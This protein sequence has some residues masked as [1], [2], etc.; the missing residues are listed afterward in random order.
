MLHFQL[1][2]G[3]PGD[4][5][6]KWLDC[7]AELMEMGVH[8]EY[9]AYPFSLLP[10]SRAGSRAYQEEWSIGWIERPDFVAYYYLKD[11][12]LNWAL[13]YS[14]YVV[15]T[16]SYNRKEYKK[17][18][19]LCWLIQAL[20]DHGITRLIAIALHHGGRMSYRE[21]YRLL[22]GWFYETET[23]RFFSQRTIDHIDTWLTDQ[24]HLCSNT[25]KS[26]MA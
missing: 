3:C 14:R 23:M 6:D 18:W 11:N 5:F 21:F 22:Y 16:S 19:L 1:I 12:S 15:E 25:M 10:N 9:R 7:F 2:A 20:H 17:M 26:W 13:S 24:R 8:G 4:T